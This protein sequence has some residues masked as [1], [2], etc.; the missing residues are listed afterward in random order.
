MTLDRLPELTVGLVGADE[1]VGRCSWTANGIRIARSRS[2]RL[3]R[4]DGAT[5]ALTRRYDLLCY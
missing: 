1:F 5:M 2:Y 4:Y 3:G